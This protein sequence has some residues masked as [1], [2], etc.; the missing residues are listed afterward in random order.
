MNISVQTVL[1][2][3]A[4]SS[5][6]LYIHPALLEALVGN[7]SKAQSCA[8]CLRQ[9]SFH[10]RVPSDISGLESMGWLSGI[11]HLQSSWPTW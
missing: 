1:Q 4:F 3:P 9:F 5:Y 2:D 10:Y 11:R 7:I 6:A 8:I